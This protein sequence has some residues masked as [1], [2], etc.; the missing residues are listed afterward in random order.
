MHFV[1]IIYSQKINKFYIGESTNIAEKISWHNNHLFK[2]SFT[3][4]SNDWELKLSI[5]V[6]NRSEARVIESYIKSMKSS[7]FINKL[8]NDT[9]FYN[10]FRIII[11]D[12]FNINID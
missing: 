5:K 11:K 9:E 10:N 1:Y 12:K 3:K 6:S 2:D 4:Q 7:K 8:S